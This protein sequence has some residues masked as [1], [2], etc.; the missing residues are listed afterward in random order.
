MRRLA[1]VLVAV[2]LLDLSCGGSPARRLSQPAARP[3]GPAS[4]LTAPPITMGAT[5]TT[6]PGTLAQTH[7]LPS[8]ADPSFALRIGDLWQAIVTG[9][10]TIASPAF[11]PESAYL[12]TKAGG[13]NAADWRYRL[14]SMYRLDIG[15]AHAL[16]GP[17]APGAEFVS[18]SVPTA[19]AAWVTPGQEQ[20]K[21]PYYR[22]YGTRLTYWL[23]GRTRSFGIYSMIS[24][25]GQWYVVHL[26]P[27]PRTV[28]RGLVYQ[29]AG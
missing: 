3:G 12:Q 10:S 15:A 24:W 4:G 7:D 13:K 27:N 16:L 17:D 8:P 19:R 9:D 11:F 23:D 20:N 29:P 5:T 21:G 6:D 28:N 22:V 25:R 14:L 1:A 18:V 2:A 26:G